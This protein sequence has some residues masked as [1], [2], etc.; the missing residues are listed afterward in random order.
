MCTSQQCCC[1]AHLVAL[2]A[3]RSAVAADPTLHSLMLHTYHLAQQSYSLRAALDLLAI[4]TASAQTAAL[5]LDGWG[6]AEQNRQLGMRGTDA[7]IA[8]MATRSSAELSQTK[9][10]E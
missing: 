10:A 8:Q 4:Q 1:H 2:Y 7:V 6:F 3:Q 9:A 5:L